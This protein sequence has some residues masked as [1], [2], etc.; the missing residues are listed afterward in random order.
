[1][2]DGSGAVSPVNGAPAVAGLP[3]WP[4]WSPATGITFGAPAV[5]EQGAAVDGYGDVFVLTA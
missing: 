5:G 2:L 4:G 3:A 1:M